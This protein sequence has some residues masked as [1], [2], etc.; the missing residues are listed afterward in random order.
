MFLELI[1]KGGQDV[2]G[3]TFPRCPKC[4]HSYLLTLADKLKKNLLRIVHK[5]HSVMEM[6]ILFDQRDQQLTFSLRTIMFAS[7]LSIAI[8]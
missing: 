7:W 8:V 6:K 3:P 1:S 2:T 4:T 5:I